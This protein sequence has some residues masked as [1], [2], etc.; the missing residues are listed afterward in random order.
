MFVYKEI[1]IR[2]LYSGGGGGGKSLTCNPCHG[3]TSTCREYIVQTHT[4]SRWGHRGWSSPPGSPRPPCWDSPA[5]RHTCST[6]IFILANE[7]RS[8]SGSGSTCFWAS[9]I[10]IHWSDIWIRILLLSSKNSKKNLD[11]Y[12]FVTSL[13]LFN[14]EK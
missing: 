10:R 5:L 8:G 4:G 12:C 11:S 1:L 2:K 3:R 6:A 7:Q 14:Y 13:G 9:R